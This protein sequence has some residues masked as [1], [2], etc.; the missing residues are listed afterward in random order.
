MLKP[1]TTKVIVKLDPKQTHWAATHPAEATSKVGTIIAPDSWQMQQCTGVVV[2]C[3]P[4]IKSS[5]MLLSV[6]QRVLF[7]K[8]NGHVVPSEYCDSDEPDGTF[9]L[10]DSRHDK[11]KPHVPEVYALL[12]DDTGKALA[13]DEARSCA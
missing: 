12:F 11:P 9:W 10:L 2:A 8:Y 4:G 3:G 1:L 13:Y 7:G 5:P 6:G